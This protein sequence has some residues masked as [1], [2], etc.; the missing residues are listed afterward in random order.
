MVQELRL[1]N[2][3]L[4]AN[5]FKRVVHGERGDYVEFERDQIIPNLISKF[6]N[7]LNESVDYYYFWLYPETDYNVKVYLQLKTVKYADYK[8]GLYYVSPTAFLNFKD[9]EKLFN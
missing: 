5:S 7:D 2:N 6:N 1:L 4:F 3:T 8:V 9:P